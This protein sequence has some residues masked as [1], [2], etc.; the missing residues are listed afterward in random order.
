MLQSFEFEKDRIHCRD[1]VALQ[2][3]VPYVKRLLQLFPGIKDGTK[4]ALSSDEIRHRVYQFETRRYVERISQSPLEFNSDASSFKEFLENGQQKVLQLEIVKGDEWTTLIKVH[5]V[6]QKTGCLIEGQ[7]TVL[8]LKRMLKLHQLMDFSELMQSSV[9]PYLL[10][11]DCVDNQQL[12]GETKDIIRTILDTIKRKPNIKVIFTTRTES[13]TFTFLH[14]MG[15]RIF[16]NGFVRRDEQL[17][18]SDLTTSSRSKLLEKPVIF[19]GTKI[20]L[21]ELTSV[22]SQAANFLSLGALVEEKKLT[23]ADPLPISNDYNEGYYIG[24]T[25]RQKKIIEENIQN[26]EKYDLIANTEQDFKQLCQLNPQKNVH[27]L[28]KDKAGKLVWQQSQGSLE[29][30]RKYIDT[31]SSHTY[32]A[33]DLDKLLEQAESQ[34]SDAD[35]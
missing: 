18:W 3:L 6:L 9:T 23:I 1:A 16:G 8:K 30:L 26:D 21:N 34:K 27:W 20:S 17:T 15:R 33:D 28:E 25:L 32:T 2:A 19:Q 31:E 24:R 10:L 22:E 11:I 12:D 7:Y 5:K 29:T 4:H 14:H 13:S 35:F